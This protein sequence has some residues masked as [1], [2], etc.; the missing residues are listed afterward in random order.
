[1]QKR[2]K[3]ESDPSSQLEQ[4]KICESVQR[5]SWDMQEETNLVKKISTEKT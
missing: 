1:M 4:M 2:A 3:T 5:D